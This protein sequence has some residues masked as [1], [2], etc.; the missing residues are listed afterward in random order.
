MTMNSP[1]AGA[2]NAHP[3][4]PGSYQPNA[5]ELY[6][7]LGIVYEWVGDCRNEGYECP[8]RDGSPWHAGE[9]T[10]RM[11]R[12]RSWESVPSYLRLSLRIWNSSSY[13]ATFSVSALLGPY[14]DGSVTGV[15]NELPLQTRRPLDGDRTLLRDLA[16]CVEHDL[17]PRVLSRQRNRIQP[18]PAHPFARKTCSRRDPLLPLVL[19][20]RNPICIQSHE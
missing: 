2:D 14:G 3:V 6:D 15:L 7:V 4:P 16:G 9:C 13:R 19:H 5:F 1:H 20:E 12:G 10:R 18:R 17:V 11:L 8:P